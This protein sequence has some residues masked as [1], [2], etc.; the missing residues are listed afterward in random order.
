[1]K[2][3]VNMSEWFSNTPFIEEKQYKQEINAEGQEA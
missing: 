2:V 1:M 3:K